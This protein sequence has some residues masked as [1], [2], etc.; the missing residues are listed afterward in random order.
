[1]TNAAAPRAERPLTGR[2]VAA[3]FVGG[4]S[5]IVSVNLALAFNAV[6][7]FPGLETKSAYVASQRFDAERAAQ[8]ALGWDVRLRVE[9]GRIRLSVRDARGAPV[10]PE[11]VRAVLGRATTVAD[12][13][14]PAFAWD[15]ADLVARTDLGPG[16]WNLR[17]EM[18]A[19][20]GTTFRRRIPLRIAP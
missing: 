10:R 13:R 14:T 8:E 17:L 3:L 18:R 12:D 2:R 11:I 1:M 6:R 5:V 19:P 15:G 9:A 16:N 4:F 7:T 20:D